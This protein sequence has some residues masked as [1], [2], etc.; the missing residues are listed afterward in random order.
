MILSGSGAGDMAFSLGNISEY[1]IIQREFYKLHNGPVS[2][3]SPED[4]GSPPYLPTFLS[5]P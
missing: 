2:L 4:M 1:Q 5:P 3:I